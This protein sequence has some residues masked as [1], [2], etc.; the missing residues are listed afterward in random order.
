[1]EENNYMEEDPDRELEHYVWQ[2]KHEPLRKIQE[3]MKEKFGRTKS[4]KWIKPRRD[5]AIQA[6]QDS[7]VEVEIPT[8]EEIKDEGEET[9]E[10]RRDEETTV[11]DDPEIIKIKSEIRCVEAEIKLIE[12]RDRLAEK[13]KILALA[14]AGV[15]NIKE[16]NVAC[17]ATKQLLSSKEEEISKLKEALEKV[18]EESGNYY[19]NASC[20]KCKGRFLWKLD[21]V[22]LICAVCEGKYEVVE[23]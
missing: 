1:M 22:N 21:D 4:T 15:K 19:P 9:D 5:A 17:L 23:D 6:Q 20:P 10:T 7:E 13:E 14:I 12:A 16:L 3:G 11:E 18:M 8:E 2:H